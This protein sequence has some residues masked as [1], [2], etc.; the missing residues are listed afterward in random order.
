M[1]RLPPSRRLVLLMPLAAWSVHQLRYLLTYGTGSGRE[2]STQ[3]HDYLA[4]LA[5]AVVV[6]A[7]LALGESIVRL[8]RAWTHGTEGSSPARTTVRLW[9]VVAAALLAIYACQE[10]LEGLLATGHPGGLAGV[11][12]HGGWWA[13]PSALLVGGLVAFGFRGARAV[14]ALLARRS[15]RARRQARSPSLRI[16]SS[17]SLLRPT[18]LARM[19]AG[20][21]PPV[22][23]EP[24]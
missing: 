20:R 18:P 4:L 8:A 22:G 14:E 1:R 24:V 12:G 19:G 5:P 13:A 16:P 7:A 6:L 23:P 2:L 11:F 10:L 21:A 17:A 3:G 9:I 15:S